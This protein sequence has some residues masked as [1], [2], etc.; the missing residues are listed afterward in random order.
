MATTTL[1]RVF[2]HGAIELPDPNA[3]LTPEQVRNTYAS[4]YAELATAS[5][6][7]PD[8]VDGKEIYTF[9]EVVGAKG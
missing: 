1:K 5:I 7:G 8:Y 3:S 6:K 2:K 4:S 9:K